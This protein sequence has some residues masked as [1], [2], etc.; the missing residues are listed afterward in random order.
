MLIVTATN[1]THER[2]KPGKTGKPVLARKDGT[3]DY[4][5]WVGINHHCIWHGSLKGHRRDAGAAKLLRLIADK[6][7]VTALLQAKTLF[8]NLAK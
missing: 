6:M 8:D 3:A 2:C 4:D 1:V 5:V 7:D